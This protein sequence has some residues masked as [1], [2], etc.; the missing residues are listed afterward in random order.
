MVAVDDEL[1]HEADLVAGS[2]TQKLDVQ[3]LADLDPRLFATCV[4]HRVHMAA[5]IAQVVTG[6]GRGR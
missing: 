2:G 4:D 1:G 5:T 3:L 6:A